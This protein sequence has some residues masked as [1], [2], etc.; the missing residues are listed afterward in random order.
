MASP[1]GGERLAGGDDYTVAWTAPNVPG[2]VQSLSLS[3][4]GGNSFFLLAGNIPSTSQRFSVT[5]PRVSTTRGRLRLLVVDPVFH[6]STFAMSQADFT[7]GS[8]VDSNIDLTFLSSERMDLN[9]SDTSSDDPPTTASGASRLAIDIRITNRGS[10]P[11]LNPFI[12]VA[13][14]NKNVLLTRDA[15]SSWGVTARQTIDAGN[16]NILSPGESADAR[17]VVGLITNKKFF[18]SVDLYG[19]PSGGTILSSNPTNIWSGKPR[20]R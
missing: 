6:N 16:D 10:I 9:W 12:R 17:L 13:E 14:L 3:T 5:L 11:I 7:I 20:T 1:N 15:K 2:S 4:D 8:N 18:L 19:V